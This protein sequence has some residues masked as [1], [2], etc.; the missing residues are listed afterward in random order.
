MDTS[1]TAKLFELVARALPKREHDPRARPSSDRDGEIL[2]RAF[3]VTAD[4][5]R[6]ALTLE[7]VRFLQWRMLELERD[8]AATRSNAR[9]PGWD[10]VS[11]F[12][13][14]VSLP[15]E[16]DDDR[17]PEV[18]EGEVRYFRAGDCCEWR[19]YEMETAGQP[20]AKGPRCLVF[21]ADAFARRVWRYPEDWKSLSDAALEALSWKA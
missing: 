19:V 10:G 8:A 3:H 9:R 1:N 15:V 4:Q 16:V 5:L 14:E 21:Q 7:S 20:W 18:P 6:R 11:L 13:R 12:E 17:G 2:D